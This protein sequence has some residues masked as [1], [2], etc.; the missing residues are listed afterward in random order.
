MG[1]IV[2]VDRFAG[3]ANIGGARDPQA[4]P[5]RSLRD[6]RNLAVLRVLRFCGMELSPARA[7]RYSLQAFTQRAT[8]D[9]QAIDCARIWLDQV[10]PAQFNWIDAQVMSDLVEMRLHGVT[11]LRRAVPTLGT[12]GRLVGEEAHTLELIRGQSIR[13]RLQRARVIGRG[14]AIRAIR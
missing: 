9:A 12:A 8:G 7:F 4:A 1:Q 6:T 2:P 10:A 3:P 14:D 11:R 5:D 13:D